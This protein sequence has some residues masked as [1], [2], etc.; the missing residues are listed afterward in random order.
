MRQNPGIAVTLVWTD[1]FDA[2][3]LDHNIVVAQKLE[4]FS[5]GYYNPAWFYYDSF[6]GG[7]CGFLVALSRVRWG[8]RGE[9]Q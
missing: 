7:H 5:V 3:A 6:A 1:L 8:R 9:Q 2:V 4:L